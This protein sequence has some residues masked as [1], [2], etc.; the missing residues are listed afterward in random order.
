VH[1]SNQQSEGAQYQIQ[2]NIEQ[3][4]QRSKFKSGQ[5]DGPETGKQ[6]LTS[7][8]LAASPL[9]KPKYRSVN[10]VC[11]FDSFFDYDINWL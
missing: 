6:K 5:K 4:K 9:R 1:G 2:L 10:E 11:F 3:E 8:D 7:A